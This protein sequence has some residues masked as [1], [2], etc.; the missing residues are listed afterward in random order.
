MSTLLAEQDISAI[1]FEPVYGVVSSGTATR[2]EIPREGAGRWPTT[3][4]AL[5]H[6]NSTSGVAWLLCA[7]QSLR[8]VADLPAGWD[9]EGSPPLEQPIVE[10]TAHLLANIARQGFATV[11]VPAVCPIAGGSLQ[12]EFRS[13]MSYLELEFRDVWT[14]SVLLNRRGAYE[15]GRCSTADVEAVCR[16]L[17][18]FIRG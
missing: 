2:V 3:R 6:D 13:K 1:P 8:D 18:R 11:P 7:L 9:G 14:I 4:Q 16:W 15:Q 17:E 10:A 12:V 5:V